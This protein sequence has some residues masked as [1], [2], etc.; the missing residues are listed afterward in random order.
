MKKIS[1]TIQIQIFLGVKIRH[2]IFGTSLPQKELL[3]GFDI[4][5]ILPYMKFSHEGL[6]FKRHFLPW[7]TPQTV[8]QIY[9]AF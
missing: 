4:I 3:I 8:S 9:Y 6:R 2:K 5:Q 1:K 7:V